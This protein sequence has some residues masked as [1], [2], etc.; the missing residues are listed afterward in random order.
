MNI[1]GEAT[2]GCFAELS[3]ESEFEGDLWDPDGVGMKES[4]NLLGSWSGR[5]AGSDLE[6]MVPMSFE[7]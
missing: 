7:V 3:L 5:G 1:F 2:G 4:L 6:P